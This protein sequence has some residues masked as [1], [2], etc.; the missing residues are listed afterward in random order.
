LQY[1]NNRKVKIPL[2]DSQQLDSAVQK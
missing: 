1:A 2:L